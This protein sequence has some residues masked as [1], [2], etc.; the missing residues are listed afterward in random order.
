M[1]ENTAMGQRRNY[2]LWACLCLCGAAWAWRGL[3]RKL[4]GQ[5]ACLLAAVGTLFAWVLECRRES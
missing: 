3:S 4:A 1:M 5:A 2:L